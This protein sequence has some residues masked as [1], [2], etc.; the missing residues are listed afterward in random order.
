MLQIILFCR[1]DSLYENISQAHKKSR[2]S[3]VS[4]RTCLVSNQ[5]STGLF[6]TCAWQAV[7]S[8]VS[9]VYIYIDA[10]EVPMGAK[11]PIFIRS[12]WETH[13]SWLR[14]LILALHSYPMC[15]FADL[16]AERQTTHPYN[17]QGASVID[18]QN[19]FPQCRGKNGRTMSKNIQTSIMLLKTPCA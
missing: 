17:V 3:P 10:L 5:K 16:R 2:T 9:C 13:L 15:V 19:V 12:T 8:C 4:A 11:A 18:F 1:Y 14:A 6:V 7:S